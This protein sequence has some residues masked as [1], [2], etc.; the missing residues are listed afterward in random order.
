MSLWRRSR[1]A[2]LPAQPTAEASHRTLRQA[3]GRNRELD[4]RSDQ[5]AL[6]LILFE[7]VSL[8]LAV[9]GPDEEI[10]A[11]AARG[12][13]V[14]LEHLSKGE[15]IPPEL[16]A[17][18]DKATAHDR[19]HRYP[20]IAALADDVRRYLRNRPVSARP[21]TPL[22]ALTRWVSRHGRLTLAVLLGVVAISA[23]AI[24]W[25]SYRKAMGELAARRRGASLTALYS[26][27]AAR[28][29][30]VVRTPIE[31][32]RIATWQ[33]FGTSSGLELDRERMILSGTVAGAK[34]RL[35]LEGEPMKLCTV[36]VVEWPRS[37]GLGLSITRQ[38]ALHS[39]AELFG[40]QDIRIG[41]VAFD[42][43]FVIKGDAMRIPHA[44][45]DAAM[46][47]ALL[48][49]ALAAVEV[50]V[51]D[52]RLVVRWPMPVERELELTGAVQRVQPIVRALCPAAV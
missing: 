32:A 26:D 47:R 30:T 24:S 8:R 31:E 13:K 46:R 41:D 51:D 29:A 52:G 35:G 10:L 37:L 48:E 21:D 16:R 14:P 7:L 15:R 27:V 36:L 22:E 43:A 20:S 1:W 50:V 44:L 6:G 12:Q 23:L 25:T 34:V 28:R 3:E 5:Y 2:S 9:V 4:A 39:I 11:N 45:A 18:V 33:S 40:A 42:D 38:H 19:A 49:L 17:I